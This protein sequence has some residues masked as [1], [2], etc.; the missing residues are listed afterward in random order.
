MTFTNPGAGSDPFGSPLD[1]DPAEWMR[2][3]LLERRT[4]ALTGALDGR[5]A[6]TAAAELMSL[7]ASGDDAVFLHV[8]CVGGNLE[9]AFTVIDTIDLLGVPV[10]AR[11]VGRAEGVGAGIVAVAHHRSATPHSRF[12]LSVPDVALGGS[13]SDI[14]A[15]AREHQRRM[16]SFVARVSRATGRAFEHVEADLER[17]RWLDADEALEYGLIDEIERPEPAAPDSER[18]RFGFA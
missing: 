7:D 13:A 2:A 3:Q 18:P 4:V 9:A 16:E 15:N 10:R 12:K 1:R 17:G 14:E 5:A 6:T 11:C 8:D